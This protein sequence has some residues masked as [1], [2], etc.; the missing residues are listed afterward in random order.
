MRAKN[1]ESE[2]VEKLERRGTA[3]GEGMEKEKSL[4]DG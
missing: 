1:R 2:Q 3:R 4:V